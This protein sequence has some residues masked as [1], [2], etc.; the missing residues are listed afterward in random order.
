MPRIPSS[1]RGAAA[2][3]VLLTLGC[4]GP[5]ESPV[6]PREP[7]TPAAAVPASGVRPASGVQEP[8]LTPPLQETAERLQLRRERAR[9]LAGQYVERGNEAFERADFQ[10]ALSNFAS[11]LEVDPSNEEARAGMR[12]TEA[13]LGQRGAG[14]A[15]FA[16][17][18]KDRETIRRAEAL[19]AAEQAILDGDTALRASQHEESIARY[20]EALVILRYHPLLQREGLTEAAV[21]SRIEAAVADREAADRR[22]ASEVEAEASRQRAEREAAAAQT[23]QRRIESLFREAHVS[24]VNERYERA[25]RLLDEVLALEPEHEE[26]HELK[27]IVVAARHRATESGLRQKLREEWQKTFTEL[28]TMNIP[29]TETLEYDLRRWAE[30]AQRTPREMVGSA[31]PEEEEREVLARLSQTTFPAKFDEAGIAEVAAF[32]QN[33]TG[34]NFILSRRVREEVPEEEKTI[35]GIDLRQTSVR[36][37]LDLVA[38]LTPLGWRVRNGVVTIAHKEELRGGQVLA[39]YEVRDIVNPVRDFPAPEINLSPSGATEPAPEDLPE[40]PFLVINADKLVDLIR[41]TIE[42]LSWEEDERNTINY[43]NGT[44][45]V[46]QTPGVQTQIGELLRD[47]REATGIM[48][49][50]QAR[51]LKVADSFLEDIGI[52]WRGLGD[53]SGGV[54]LPGRGTSAILDDFGAVAGSPASP[55]AIGTGSD[56]GAFYTVGNDDLRARA[57]NLFDL[58]LGSQDILVGSGGLSVQYTLLDDTQLELILRA[59]SK[60]ERV[61]EVTASRLLVFNTARSNLRVLNQVTYVKDFDVEIA[62]A[63]AVADPII[64]VVSDGVF[65]DV[66]PVVSADRRFITMELRPTVAVLQRPIPEAQTSL[67]VGS[68]VTIQL[69]ELEVQRAR[70]TVTMPDRGTI[71]LGGQK[72]SEKQD[73]QSGVPI[74]NRIPLISA[75][76]ERK[77]KFVSNRKL[78]ILIKATIVIPEEHEPSLAAASRAR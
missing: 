33:L 15:E 50:I 10:G 66:R 52:D 27:E 23:R 47:L 6:T 3:A 39:F 32:L 68:P 22:A 49:D 42:P 60:S 67:G 71:L 70:T 64:D 30:V 17:D 72:I 40:R 54:G 13:I 55:G 5:S 45:V 78:L 16:Q 65:L 63:S 53:D 58:G 34:V 25:E 38:E 56:P 75:L 18:A 2:A 51:F 69:P 1:L 29:Q 36:K 20:R 77:A 48:V 73:F 37:L 76:F 8:T 35:R 19:L 12:R 43:Q 74:L 41:S 21:Q 4:Q 14:A 46:S 11:A 57:E 28:D 59:V 44:L 61:E 9:I 7:A 26:A 31:G 24:F 62:Q